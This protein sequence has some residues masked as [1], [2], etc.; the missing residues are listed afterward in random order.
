MTSPLSGIVVLGIFLVIISIFVIG[1]LAKQKRKRKNDRSINTEYDYEKYL[2]D[3][4]Q[5]NKDRV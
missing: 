3:Q 4:E 2:R 5:A 1:Y